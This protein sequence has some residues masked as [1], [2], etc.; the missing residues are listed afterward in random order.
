M[1]VYEITSDAINPLQE[2]TFATVGIR[3]RCDLQRLLK[4]SF[5]VIDPD[6]MIIGEEFGEWE[7]SRRR[8]DLL[9]ID[10]T[11]NL[12]VVELKRT[13]DGGH[14][15][16]QSIRYAAMVST[17]TFAKIV[18]VHDT[19]LKRCGKDTDAEA[20]I[21]EFLGWDEPNQEEFGQDVRIIL[22]S[23]EFSRELTTSVMWLNQ[24]EIDIRCI[25]LKPY[26]L[27]LQI[28]L[29]VQQIIPLPESTDYQVRIR[30]KVVEQ[31]QARTNRDL[32]RFDVTIEGLI[33]KNL[34]KRRM[35]FEV[36]KTM[37]EKGRT[38]EELLPFLPGS[39]RWLIVEGECSEEDFHEKATK[40]RGMRGAI[41]EPRRYFNSD[42]ELFRING[43]TY[44]LT[45][46]WGTG[47]I[48][49]MEAIKDKYPEVQIGYVEAS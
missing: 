28:L 13:E 43:K 20:A 9:G 23:A 49:A 17:M 24:R 2:T 32:T 27:G 38:P 1:P 12:V 25:R 14:M 22:V 6:V 34:P 11:G 19:Y 4:E 36:V 7:D 42:D 8:I 47:T 16:L 30:E 39:E 33:H 37:V 46:M 5:A 21:L 31:R 29:D 15:E 3:E 48:P 18:S 45:K 26:R 44:A 41:Y 35:I 40:V 10:R